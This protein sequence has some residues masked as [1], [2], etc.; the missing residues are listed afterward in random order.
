MNKK[1]CDA[2]VQIVIL[3]I[4]VYIVDDEH[5]QT[6]DCLVESI[7]ICTIK[8]K[9]KKK[10]KNAKKKTKKKKLRSFGIGC[11]FSKIIIYMMNKNSCDILF[12]YSL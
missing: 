6:C 3:K 8:K 1:I 11:S 4:S 5:K 12:L 10:K 9:K 7:S 2:L